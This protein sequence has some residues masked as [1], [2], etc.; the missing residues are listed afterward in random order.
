MP[1]YVFTLTGSQLHN[2]HD[3]AARCTGATIKRTP[4][5][6]SPL[7]PLVTPT[8]SVLRLI[9]NPDEAPLS[10]EE[11]DALE[12]SLTQFSRKQGFVVPPLPAIG[13]R[14]VSP[15]LLQGWGTVLYLRNAAAELGEVRLGVQ[16]A[17]AEADADAATAQTAGVAVTAEEM[18]AMASASDRMGAFD[19][20]G[21]AATGGLPAAQA[22][23]AW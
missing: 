1:P 5:S 3:F 10:G 6:L 15:D 4:P 18:A 20:G 14:V 23:P 12:G 16:A 13:K 9:L 19:G 22:N 7:P 8:D 11:A 21:I 17:Q 2:N